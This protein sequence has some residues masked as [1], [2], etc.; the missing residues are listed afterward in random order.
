[1]KLLSTIKSFFGN[2]RSKKNR[3][4]LSGQTFENYLRIKAELRASDINLSGN[5]INFK[6]NYR[7][8][9]VPFWL[10]DNAQAAS[11]ETDSRVQAAL[12]AI[13]VGL[14]TD[15]NLVEMS[16]ILKEKH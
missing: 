8:S 1:M 6:V 14:A 12:D 5:G 16:Q 11:A 9:V 3:P 7:G 15:L 13:A 2:L 4:K 10:A